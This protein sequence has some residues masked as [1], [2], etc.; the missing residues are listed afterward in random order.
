MILMEKNDET[1]KEVGETRATDSCLLKTR[2]LVKV[3]GIVG[4]QMRMEL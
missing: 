3:Y 1:N 4:L 2:K